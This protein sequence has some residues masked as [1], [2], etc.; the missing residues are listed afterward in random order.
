[1]A[2]ERGGHGVGWPRE[3]GLG[4][5]RAWEDMARYAPGT[6]HLPCLMSLNQIPQPMRQWRVNIL[7]GLDDSILLW[8]FLII[9]CCASDSAVLKCLVAPVPPHVLLLC[10]GWARPCPGCG[11]RHVQPQQRSCPS[12]TGLDSHRGVSLA[13]WSLH[14]GPGLWGFCQSFSLVS[15]CSCSAP[16]PY[17]GML[18]H[19]LLSSKPWL[20]SRAVSAF[21]RALC[22]ALLS[23]AAFCS[24]V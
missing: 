19:I 2:T 7:W 18:H 3:G 23:W 10:S 1:M 17:S 24:R 8:V 5:E 14:A 6:Q 15:P 4:C 9:S 21:P 22:P 11:C 13:L 20:L 16:I 12:F